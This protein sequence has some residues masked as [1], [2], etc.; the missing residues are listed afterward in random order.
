MPASIAWKRHGC[1]RLGSEQYYNMQLDKSLVGC[2]DDWN[3]LDHFDPTAESRRMWSQFNSLRGTYGALQ[4]GFNLVQ[5]GNWTYR[6]EKPGSNQTYTE[7]GLWS[8]SRSGIDGVQTLSGTYND[9]V[10]ML[11]TNENQT[12]TWEYDCSGS[13]WISSPFVSGTTVRNLFAPFETYTLEDSGSPYNADG[14]S[15]YYG[16]LGSLTMDAYGFKAL[17]PEA[18]WVAPPV[19]MTKFSPGHDHRL[20]VHTGDTNSTTTD[21]SIEFNTEMNCDGVTS[22]ISLTMASSGKGS[23]PSISNAKCSTVTGTNNVQGGTTSAYIWTATL[24]N[25]P[26]GVLTITVKDAP[27]SSGNTT[28]VNLLSLLC[29][30][31][32]LTVNSTGG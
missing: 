31:Q 20:L 24:T 16:C 15:P 1:Y 3:A 4:D 19:A 2:Q 26:D 23:T 8:I 21:I 29:Q 6:I 7:M 10:W 13:L 17:V 30:I 22:A 9:V 12:K 14:K 5:R 27:S 28:N 18:Q 32:F 11:Y 25:F